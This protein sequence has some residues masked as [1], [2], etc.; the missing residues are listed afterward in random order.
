[1]QFIYLAVLLF[2]VCIYTESAPQVFLC[3]ATLQALKYVV[4]MLQIQRPNNM[5]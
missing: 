1:M 3:L 4:Q 5:T 2:S